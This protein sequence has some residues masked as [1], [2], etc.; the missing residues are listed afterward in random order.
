MCIHQEFEK[1]VHDYGNQI[2]VVAKDRN[3]TYNELNTLANKIAHRLVKLGVRQ[4]DKVAFSLPRESI[5]FPVIMGILKSGA[6]Y[7]PIDIEY[8][9]ERTN[10]ILQDCNAKIFISKENIREFIDEK[11]SSNLNLD[12]DSDSLCYCLYTSGSTGKPKGVMIKHR[13]IINYIGNNQYNFLINDMAENCDNIISITT[14]CFDVFVTESIGALIY[15]KKIIFADEEQSRLKENFKELILKHKADMIE[16]TPSK[17]KLFCSD[18]DTDYLKKIK[19]IALAGE[20]TDISLLERLKKTTNAR[21]YDMYGPT[22][23]T[24]YATGANLSYDSF[25]HIGKPLANTKVYIVDKY[26]QPVPIG[27]IGELC[28]AGD[29][30]GKGYLNRPELTDEKFIDDPF[31]DGKLYKTGDLA[32]W[33]EDGN[34]VYVGRNDFQVK[35]R[36]LRIELG[37]IENAISDI[38]GVE[39]CAVVVRENKNKQFIC[40]FYT[41]KEL[42]DEDIRNVVSKTLPKYMIPHIYKH[43][44]KMPT[45][46][47][48]K[49]NRKLLPEVCFDITVQKKDYTAPRTR[50]EKILCTLIE[51]V[52]GIQKVGIDDDF[53]SIGMDSL[54][55]IEFISAAREAGI[56]IPLQNT[57]D[58]PTVSKLSK[59]LDENTHH[60]PELQTKELYSLNE[61]IKNNCILPKNI[62]DKKEIGNIL[63]AGATG[64]LGI[65]ILSDYLD[66]YTGIAYCLVRGK[67]IADSQQRFFELLEFYFGDKYT[68]SQRIK[69]LCADISEKNFLVDENTYNF[70]LKNI[71]TVI[72]SAASV[73]HYGSY[74][75]FYNSN[76]KTTENMISFCLKANAEY[77]HISTLSV[78][79]NSFADDFNINLSDDTIDFSEKNFYVDQPIDNVY[80]RSKF[81]AEKLVLE[82]IKKGLKANIMRMGNLTNRYSDGKFQKNHYSNAFLKRMK[83]FLEIGVIPDYL[84]DI[85]AEF[86][87]VDE[88][89]RAVMSVTEHFSMKNTIF[90]INSDKVVYLDTLV[91]LINSV[92]IKMAISNSETFTDM[93]H[94]RHILSAFINDLD[95]NNKLNYESNIHIENRFTVEYLKKIGFEWSP[96]NIDYIRKYI[97]YFKKIGYLE[98]I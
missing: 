80:A 58:Y 40:A 75:Y 15:G 93:V 17:M 68:R 31:G 44:E 53:T 57:F 26:M 39:Q 47:N 56:H 9:K 92:G 69:I 64:Y 41:G 4:G 32:Y 13:N 48:S 61:V 79:G 19:I 12:I 55:I 95:E 42:S 77:I 22:E 71:Q 83:A 90:H 78:S 20:S 18:N 59:S 3:L 62:P 24:V 45:T 84:S 73:K 67:D 65:H 74:E 60:L 8:P 30:V 10:F 27:I 91:K 88:A 50:R 54:M 5:I 97:E 29:G 66:N 51:K 28:I 21:I 85:Y 43:L 16:I 76:V 33:R 52:S 11:E 37:E 34:I 2:A 35:I 7:V 63:I 70:L 87:P 89:A 49:I 86:T 94:D 1:T 6:A 46:S 14:V 72:N 82:N 25:V 81:L 36:G 98:W 96:I 38:D 23:T